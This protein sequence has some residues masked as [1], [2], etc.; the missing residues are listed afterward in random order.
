VHWHL[1]G[2]RKPGK[3]WPFA[4][5]TQDQNHLYCA[6][7]IL[8]GFPS[9]SAL[10]C[11]F[12]AFIKLFQS[13]VFVGFRLKRDTLMSLFGMRRESWSCFTVVYT[14]HWAGRY[15]VVG[16]AT[17]LAC[18]LYYCVWIVLLPRL[19][20]YDIVEEVEEYEDGA[21]NTKLV[22]R[23]HNSERHTLLSGHQ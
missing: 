22:R 19:G 12:S 8:S 7:R 6:V 13:D 9:F 16:I 10:V 2:A 5:A 20:G 18:G 17:I 21:R 11:P 15:C 3:G 23:Y 1:Q 4:C 14:D